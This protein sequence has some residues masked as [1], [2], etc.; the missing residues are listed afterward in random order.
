MWLESIFND[1]SIN[2]NIDGFDT[3]ETHSGVITGLRIP[4][5][6]LPG[7]WSIASFTSYGFQKAELLYR[8]TIKE[9]DTFNVM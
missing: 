7:D 8:V 1:T 2:N 6:L 4:V 9:I 5:L 3:E